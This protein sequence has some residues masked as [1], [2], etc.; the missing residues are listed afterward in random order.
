MGNDFWSVIESIIAA[1][2]ILDIDDKALAYIKS[3]VLA[4]AR[5]GRRR[6]VLSKIKKSVNLVKAA[7]MFRPKP[8]KITKRA[9]Q[10]HSTCSTPLQNSS[11]S[12][13]ITT[14]SSAACL[15]AET[16]PV[17]AATCKCDAKASSSRDHPVSTKDDIVW[18]VHR[19]H[20]NRVATDL[21]LLSAELGLVGSSGCSLPPLQK[22]PQLRT[23]VN[24]TAWTNRTA[25]NHSNMIDHGRNAHSPAAV[26]PA[27]LECLGLVSSDTPAVSDSQ[28]SCCIH[29]CC[30]DLPIRRRMCAEQL[31]RDAKSCKRFGRWI[32]KL[33]SCKR[34]SGNTLL[35]FSV[36]KRGKIPPLP[37]LEETYI[38]YYTIGVRGDSRLS[39]LYLAQLLFASPIMW[40]CWN[41][42]VDVDVEHPWVKRAA[43]IT[44]WW[45]TPVTIAMALTSATWQPLVQAT[46]TDVKTFWPA[47]LGVRGRGE[48][49]RAAVT[50]L[51]VTVLWCGTF[52]VSAT[53]FSAWFATW[54]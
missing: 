39:L 12:L 38:T 17:N 53:H 8:S 31:D 18:G 20:K 46:G 15:A 27:E 52:W 22:E 36:Q 40:S 5:G 48:I 2:L 9:Q 44:T 29:G 24:C 23:A 14:S 43:F 42:C 4:R 54:V 41:A 49:Y 51:S 21:D 37:A 13:A 33:L 35:P 3:R 50:L 30:D 1:F 25:S 19:E 6:L 10:L 32:Y 11:Q 7:N 26:P 28:S 16:Q 45:M 47:L 34:C